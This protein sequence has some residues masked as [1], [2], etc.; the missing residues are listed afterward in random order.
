MPI[1]FL[2][3][4]RL[5]VGEEQQ[6]NYDPN[7]SPRVVL[8]SSVAARGVTLEDVKEVLIL[9]LTRTSVLHQSGLPMHEDVPMDA[10]LEKNMAG[11]A[12]RT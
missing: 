9:P 7:K 4:F 6:P 5:G 8:S 10:E 11:R 2:T 12:G 3:S 1:L